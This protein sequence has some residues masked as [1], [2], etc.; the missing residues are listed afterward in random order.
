R[1]RFGWLDPAPTGLFIWVIKP[2]GEI[3]FRSVD[4]K[5]KFKAELTLSQVVRDARQSLAGDAAPADGESD[6]APMRQ[7][8]ELLV[9]PIVD[10]LPDRPEARV[11][12]IPQDALFLVP[13]PAL[14][15]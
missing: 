13:F 12:F 3:A 6:Q 14:R 10:L 9:A 4:L 2:T 7:L 5:P 15:D 8:H 1:T 11:T